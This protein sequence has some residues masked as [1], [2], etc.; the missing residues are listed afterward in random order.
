ML[1]HLFTQPTTRD[2]NLDDPRTTMLRRHIIRSKGFL[3]KVYEEWYASIVANL[4]D[5]QGAVI[6]LGSGGGFLADRLPGLVTS[7]VFYCP[8]IGIVADGQQLPFANNSLRAIVMVDVLHHLPDVRSFFTEAGR[9][10][11]AGGVVVMIEPW[12]TPWS[13]L[14]YGRL[15][16]EPFEPE[17]SLWE[18]PARGPLSGA[19]GALPYI[20]F[21]RDRERFLAEFPEWRIQA[22]QPTM[23][24]RYLL[25]GGVSMRALMPGWS[26]TF[27][28][29][30]ERVLRPW[31]KNLAMFAIIVLVKIEADT[32]GEGPD[33][34]LLDGGSKP[35][36]VL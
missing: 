13:R 2:L 29:W 21:D 26:F 22:V 10:V 15:H 28:T 20:V 25:S 27:W 7:E 16:H 3:R 17:A 32:A 31:A 8:G 1:R 35:L 12:V 23:P 30:L 33:V 4:P 5:G 6:E 11:R 34:F 18:F 24:F 36:G 19:N 9:S 14:V